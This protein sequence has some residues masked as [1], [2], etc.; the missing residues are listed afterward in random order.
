ME[1]V[2]AIGLM[3][4]LLA[5]VIG[6][7]PTGLKAVNN[8]MQDASSK[9]IAD[10]MIA[11]IRDTSWENL[12]DYNSASG[13]NYATKFDLN[14]VPKESGRWVF[15][16]HAKVS[17]AGSASDPVQLPGNT[18]PE[19]N[20]INVTIMVAHFPDHPS[21]GEN[22]TGGKWV[23]DPDS[24]VS[25]RGDMRTYQFLLSNNGTNVQ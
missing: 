10:R 5:S 9:R 24:K 23:F 13:G 2:I 7:I 4:F 14:G 15:L 22:E 17:G 20:L 12:M 3:G 18:V 8:T 6:L 1:V 19:K 16:T 25:K 11:E 21:D